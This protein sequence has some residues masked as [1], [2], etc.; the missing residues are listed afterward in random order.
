M[1]GLTPDFYKCFKDQLGP[2]LKELLIII[3]RQQ[4]SHP[5]GRR[6]NSF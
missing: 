2:Y 1:D 6:L 5:L 4:K 3:L